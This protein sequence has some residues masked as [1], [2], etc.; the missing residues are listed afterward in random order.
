MTGEYVI[1]RKEMP[2]PK[3][4]GSSKMAE[5][6]AEKQEQ[7]SI[8]VED[9]FER[10][11]EILKL[12]ESEETGLQKSLE[13]YTEGVKLLDDCQKTLEGVRQQMEILKREG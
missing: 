3:G 6:K 1:Y 7:K 12:M 13:L 5:K 2:Y 11:E 8:K 9:A 10:V 4:D